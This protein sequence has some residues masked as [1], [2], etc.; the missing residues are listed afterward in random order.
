VCVPEAPDCGDIKASEDCATC[1]VGYTLV[2]DPALGK[3]KCVKAID[4]CDEYDYEKEECR[5][6]VGT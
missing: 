5:K 1:D 3:D 2:S 4:H 6:C